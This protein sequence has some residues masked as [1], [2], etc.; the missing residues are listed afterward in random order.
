MYNKKVLRKTTSL[1]STE[2]LIHNIAIM[3][4]PFHYFIILYFKENL[5]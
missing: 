5:G 2:I 3:N 4:L 1:L